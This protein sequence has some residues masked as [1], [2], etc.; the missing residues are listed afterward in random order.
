M[1][2]ETPS[3]SPRIYKETE[4]SILHAWKR[5][6]YALKALGQTNTMGGEKASGGEFQTEEAGHSRPLTARTV[7]HP[8]TQT[9]FVTRSQTRSASST[10]RKAIAILLET[11]SRGNLATLPPLHLGKKPAAVRSIGTLG[12]SAEDPT[13]GPLPR[14][15]RPQK[16]KAWSRPRPGVRR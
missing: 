5:M 10:G 2:T 4:T 15:P 7:K 8:S 14:H 9:T 13:G 12:A 1:T 3:F 11:S 6:K 16:C